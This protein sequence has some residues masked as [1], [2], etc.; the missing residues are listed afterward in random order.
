VKS[1]QSARITGY[2]HQTT[3]NIISARADANNDKLL[4]RQHPG[5]SEAAGVL[6]RGI[7]PREESQFFWRLP[8]A[9]HRQPTSFGRYNRHNP[10]GR[11]VAN[12][13]HTADS[14]YGLRQP[15][16][17]QSQGTTLPAPPAK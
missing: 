6:F 15:I 1:G 14:S 4:D 7:V 3:L 11:R 9:P 13:S 2:S 10:Q 16:E 5:C 12:T 17:L 8:E